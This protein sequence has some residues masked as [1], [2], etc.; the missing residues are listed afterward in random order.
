MKLIYITRNYP[1]AVGGL[2]KVNFTLSEELKKKI[3]TFVIANKRSQKWLLIF[4]VT[5]LFRAIYLSNKH[6]ITNIHLGDGLL[7][8]LGLVLKIVLKKKVTV[9]INGLD[10]TYKKFFYQK[11]IP[12]CVNRL[13][14]I[15]C[16]SHATLNECAKRGIDADK[17]TVINYGVFLN[18]FKTNSDRSDL[19]TFINRKIEEN[20][21]ILIS[22]GR[23]VPR[24]GVGW[25]IENVLPKLQTNYLYLIVG[26]GP[27]KEKIINT[28][29]KQGLESEV[30]LL[31]NISNDDLKKLYSTADLFI[32]P[33]IP[34]KGDME[35]FGMVLIEAASAG[36]FSIASNLE[37][38]SDAIIDNVTGSLITPMDPQSFIRAIEQEKTYDKES[39]MNAVDQKYS[40]EKTVDQY[41]ENF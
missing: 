23:L 40:W 31:T 26:G 15:I 27:E 38:I 32:M 1:P 6:G 2:E 28:I 5:T 10:I 8:P 29:K 35:G 22:V 7:S 11:V 21:K 4:F 19:S 14:T 25:F 37:G 17:C 12:R 13:S 30:L 36:L 9:T 41:L 3:P 20:Q 39:I 33:N 16:I 24:K 18:E 34:V